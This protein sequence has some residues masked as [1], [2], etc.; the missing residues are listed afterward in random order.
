MISNTR[1]KVL[2][3]DDDRTA[4]A[5]TRARLE[6]AGFEVITQGAALGTRATI[7]RERPAVVL[8]DVEM[9]GLK[10]DLIAQLFRRSESMKNIP[11]ILHSGQ[12]LGA[13]QERARDCGAIGAI[14][15]TGDARSF[16]AQ[17][18]RLLERVLRERGQPE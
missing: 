10:G 3:V 13:L 18:E 2:V 11:V 7:L 1:R 9:P 16:I 8:L 17:F 15:K 14:R 5:V 6:A 4:L 12:E